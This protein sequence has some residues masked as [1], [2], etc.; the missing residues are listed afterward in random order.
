[1]RLKNRDNR[2]M[3]GGLRFFQAETNFSITPW[4]SFE[5]AVSQIIVHRL[6]NRWLMEQKGWSVDP[7]YVAAELD[8]YNAKIAQDMG[9]NDYIVQG[10][11]GGLDPV[12]FPLPRTHQSSGL[13]AGSVA[14]KVK[15]GV[16]TIA[17]WEIASG[18]VVP[19]EQAEGRAATCAKCPQNV[20]GDLASWFTIPAA[21][22]IRLQLETRNNMKLQTSS[23][24]KLHV[25]EACACPLKLKVWCP[26]DIILS[27]MS[28]EVKA[29]LD[30]G[31]WILSEK[32]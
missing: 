14:A 22:L 32:A 29:A 1:M 8:S 12:P 19:R 6:G 10:D 18:I 7:A 31:C 9:W 17:E 25:C 23:D 28:A 20:K 21:R 5:S 11:P 3:P 16:Q 24:E 4:S 15:S 2:P 13:F 30:P 27:K 26:L